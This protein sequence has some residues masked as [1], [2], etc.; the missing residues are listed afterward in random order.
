MEAIDRRA[1]LILIV[2]GVA[3]V[4]AATLP[5]ATARAGIFSISKAGTEGDG[6]Y[7][8]I[9]GLI[10]A[11]LAGWILA[12]EHRKGWRALAITVCGGLIAAV[13]IWDAAD[14]QRKLGD[15]E[16][17]EISI[18]AGLWLTMIAGLAAAILGYRLWR[19]MRQSTP[20]STPLSQDPSTPPS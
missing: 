12:R 2:T 15:V 9:G 17:V 14:I 1:P 18:G 19:Q 3:L 6:V 8:L 10:I 13:G 7:T 4:I 5:W 20:S 11:A 16:G